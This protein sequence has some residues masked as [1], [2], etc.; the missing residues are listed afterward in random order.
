M[1]V[2]QHK[3][4][5]QWLAVPTVLFV[6]YYM[7]TFQLL[8]LNGYAIIV[9]LLTHQCDSLYKVKILCKYQ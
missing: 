7:I 3:L 5:N 1:P 6:K 4:V 8:E 9:E 2:D